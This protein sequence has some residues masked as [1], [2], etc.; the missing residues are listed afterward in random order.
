MQMITPPKPFMEPPVTK[1]KKTHGKASARIR[2]IFTETPDL[3]VKTVHNMLVKQG[4]KCSRGL[5]SSLKCRLKQNNTTKAR[6]EIV[7]MI[8]HLQRIKNVATEIGVPN[9][10]MLVGILYGES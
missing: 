4:V 10:K 7:V 2:E 9:F 1:A 5:V 6:G 8:D 3:S